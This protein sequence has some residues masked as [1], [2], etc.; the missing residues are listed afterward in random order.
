MTAMSPP[1]SDVTPQVE[2][3]KD[4]CE[5]GVRGEAAEKAR[6]SPAEEAVSG[7][8]PSGAPVLSSTK[9]CVAY[10]IAASHPSRGS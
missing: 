8:S 2:A 6:F 9:I 5:D 3:V 4:E 7:F 10:M 1:T